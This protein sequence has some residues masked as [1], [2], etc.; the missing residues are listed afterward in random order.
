MNTKTNMKNV[1]HAFIIASSLPCFFITAL[2]VGNAMTNHKR[3][4]THVPTETFMFG[5]PFM[6][7]IFGIINYLVTT[8]TKSTYMSSLLVGAGLG[9]TLSII[10]RFYLNLPKLMFG[11]T[12]QNAFQVHFVAM[13]LYAVIFLTIV[14][15]LQQYFIHNQR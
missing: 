2:Y 15:P 12:D 13:A 3:A 6:Y 10:G 1:I 7:G 5:I 9:L 14:M 4:I 8:N 11:Y